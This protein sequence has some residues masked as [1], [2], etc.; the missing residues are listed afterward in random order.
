MMKME[1]DDGCSMDFLLVSL[2]IILITHG[3]SSS[4]DFYHLS[5]NFKDDL[6]DF[7]N[8]KK[9]NIFSKPWVLA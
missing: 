8:I 9:S 6:K 3:R 7:K 4:K 5:V 1:L 2:W